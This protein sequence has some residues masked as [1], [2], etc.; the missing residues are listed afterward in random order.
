MLRSPS[1]NE[2]SKL[3]FPKEQIFARSLVY[4]IL[5][6]FPRIYSMN[7][8]FWKKVSFAKSVTFYPITQHRC[9]YLYT[10]QHI[11][12]GCQVVSYNI[13]CTELFGDKCMHHYLKKLPNSLE[14]TFTRIQ[15]R[16]SGSEIN[17]NHKNEVWHTFRSF[18]TKTVFIHTMFQ[19]NV[20]ILSTTESTDDWHFQ[21]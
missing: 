6:F 21:Y 16:R 13:A 9:M 2:G 12:W 10:K 4:R 8:L 1:M 15:G 19:V 14:F 3:F 18:F 17:L 11:L 20:C 7:F 5:S